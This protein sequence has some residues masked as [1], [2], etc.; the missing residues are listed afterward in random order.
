MES[1]RH[2]RMPHVRA[3]VCEALQTAKTLASGC[4]IMDS[5]D[6]DHIGAGAKAS[7]LLKMTPQRRTWSSN[8]YSPSSQ[9]SY[10]MSFTPP[11]STGDSDTSVHDSSTLSGMGSTARMKRSPLF[12]SSVAASEVLSRHGSLPHSCKY[13]L[14]TWYTL[15]SSKWFV[16]AP[17]VSLDSQNV[18]FGFCSYFEGESIHPCTRR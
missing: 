6:G 13:L 18:T 10:H 4:M 12:P 16:V 1:C 7:E 11:N 3:A 8:K 9:E 17:S 14:L 15:L 5:E 2:D